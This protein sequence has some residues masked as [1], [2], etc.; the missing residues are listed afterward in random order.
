M[1]CLIGGESL[2]VGRSHECDFPESVSN[3]PVLTEPRTRFT[4]S[5][6]VDQDVAAAL[7]DGASLY[8]LDAAKVQSLRPDVILTQDLCSVCSID[9]AS[10]RAVASEID[11]PPAVISLNPHTFEDVLDDIIRVGEAVG[12]ADD[13][14]RAV[15]ALRERF[16][17]AANYVNPFDAQKRVAVLEWTDPLFIAGHWTPQLVERAGGTHPLNETEPMPDA[18]AGAGGQMAHRIAGPSR[19]IEAA[20]LAEA[21][22]EILVICPCGLTLEQARTESAALQAMPWWNDLPAVQANQV[23]LVDGSQMFAR[24]GPRLVD[25]YVWLVAI[26]ND[27]PELLPPDFPSARL[28]SR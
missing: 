9:L 20:A 2:L 5:Q 15:I 21:A 18:G 1:L 24:P 14:N 13:A 28:E 8:R 17:H 16:F 23:Y 4:T 12:L 3:R 11:P 19:R 25:A 6:E 22:P 27:R 7:S 26:L 10:V